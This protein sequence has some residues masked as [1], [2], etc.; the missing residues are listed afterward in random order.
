MLFI[1]LVYQ[2]GFGLPSAEAMACGCMVIGY[3]GMGGKEFY[4]PEVCF[5]VET[6]N[7]VEVAKTIEQVL[8]LFENNPKSVHE[9]AAKASEFIRENYSYEIQKRDVLEFW[10]GILR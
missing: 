7:I 8:I 5:P 1:N 10:N 3:H 9:K 4:R 2:E 6:G